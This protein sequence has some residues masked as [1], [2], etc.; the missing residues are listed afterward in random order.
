[1]VVQTTSNQTHLVFLIPIILPRVRFVSCKNS[2]KTFA[3]DFLYNTLMEF[4]GIE[5]LSV[6]RWTIPGGRRDSEPYC[7]S[8][9]LS[10][11][12]QGIKTYRQFSHE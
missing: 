7:L 10:F 11:T 5:F 1:M 9:I 3:E 6:V 4:R 8:H 2:R 12:S